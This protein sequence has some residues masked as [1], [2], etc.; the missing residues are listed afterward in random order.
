MAGNTFGQI[1]RLTTF[2]ESHG[3]YTGGVIDGCP[4]GIYLD[5]AFIASEI[6][7]RKTGAGEWESSRREPD[8]VEFISG[9]LKGK[10]TGTPLAFIIKNKDARPSDYD[11]I[12]STYRPSHGD[13]T[14][15]K[16]YGLRDYR[17]GGRA[18][19]RETLA[20]VVGGAIAKMYLK[21][22]RIHI[23]GYVSQIG[24][25]KIV[26]NYKSIK[27]ET[28]RKSRLHCPD[29]EKGSEMIALLQKVNDEKDTIGG[30]VSCIL[31]GVP[32]GLGEPLFDKLEAELAKAMLSIPATKGFELGSGF[33]SSSMKG[34]EH[35]DLL[36]EKDGVIQTRTNH[37]GGIQAGISNGMD[38]Y[39]NVAFKPPPGIGKS[40]ESMD[41]E[42]RKVNLKGKGRYDVCVVPR[43]VII[44]EAMAAMVIMDHYLRYKTIR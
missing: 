27:E 15:E 40:Q 38:I 23:L 43:A 16:K 4:P 30:M 24:G 25:I 37:S 28:V 11:E 20:R 14:Y 9:L 3:K 19:A 1:F 26:E 31:S 17:G 13:F 18:S 41:V 32:A 7:K 42:G 12:K 2:G 36:M 44:V 35:N 34:S 29:E 21:Q 33:S 39:F 22:L 10:T 5:K 6:E 8:E